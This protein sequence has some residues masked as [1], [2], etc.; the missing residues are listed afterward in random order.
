MD[1]QHKAKLK[2]IYTHISKIDNIINVIHIINSN[3][4]KNYKG[5][6]ITCINFINYT[7]N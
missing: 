6:F 2:K 1:E 3:K 4:H 7:Y 5:I